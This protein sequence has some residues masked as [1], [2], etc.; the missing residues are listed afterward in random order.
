MLKEIIVLM[1]YGK[2]R[3]KTCPLDLEEPV[4]PQ[5]RKVPWYLD[6]GIA[7]HSFQS[8]EECTGERYLR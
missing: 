7:P 6:E 5:L 4:L 2:K 3:E 1:I 8:P